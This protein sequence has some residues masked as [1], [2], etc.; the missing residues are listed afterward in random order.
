[1]LWYA[2]ACQRI[3]GPAHQRG[4]PLSQH[5]QSHMAS[6]VDLMPSIDAVTYVMLEFGHRHIDPTLGHP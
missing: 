2:I 3:Y 5:T 4:M 1:M 6:W